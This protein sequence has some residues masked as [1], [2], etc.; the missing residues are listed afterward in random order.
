MKTVTIIALCVAALA[1]AY[2]VIA[3]SPGPDASIGVVNVDKIMAEYEK[4][5]TARTE[6]QTMAKGYGEQIDWMKRHALLN[7]KEITELVKLR[8][9]DKPTAAELTRAAALE[10]LDKERGNKLRALQNQPNLT[11][12]QKQELME[13]Q[14]YA[15]QSGRAIEQTRKDLQK[16]LDE[17]ELQFTKEVGVEIKTAV[18]VVSQEKNTPMVINRSAVIQGGTDLTDAVLKKL[19]GK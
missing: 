3:D 4:A 2:V 7:D 17:R 1:A 14:S 6:L 5:K 9:K 19:N 16:Q 11:A 18:G 8:L 15:T 12:Q 13:L 10:E